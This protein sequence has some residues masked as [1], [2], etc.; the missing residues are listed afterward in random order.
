MVVATDG[1]ANVGLGSFGYG[2]GS[3]SE[4][5]YYKKLGELAAEKGVTISLI[6]VVGGECNIQALSTMCERT[7]GLVHNVKANEFLESM[8]ESLNEKFIASHLTVSIQLPR[9]LKF[10]NEDSSSLSLGGSRFTRKMG[11]ANN[12]PV[13]FY[14]EYELKSVKELLEMNLD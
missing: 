4:D 3:E 13:S 9:V 11:N 7:G 8:T 10:R 1:A 6:A 5:A 2:R 12:E 14:F